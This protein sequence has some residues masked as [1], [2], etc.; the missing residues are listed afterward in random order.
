[1]MRLLMAL[2]GAVAALLVACGGSSGG[3]GNEPIALLQTEVDD[4]FERPREVPDFRFPRDHG[5]HPGFQSEW[6][7]VT[8]NLTGEGRSF[9]YQL[10]IFRFGLAPEGPVA[11]GSWA[12]RQL[13]LA[14]LAVT[15]LGGDQFLTAERISRGALDLAGAR[16]DRL[17]VHVEDFVIEATD[18]G[19][20]SVQL[21]ALDRGF[22][23]DLQLSAV[24]PIVRQGNQGLSAKGPTPGNASYYYSVP[25]WE[26]T[27]SVRVGDRDHDVTGLSWFDREWSTSALE[28][29]QSGWDW[30]AL[31]LDDGTDLMYYGLREESGGFGPYSAGVLVA[32]DGAVRKL[33]ATDLAAHPLDWWESPVTGRTY[34][35]AWRLEG[36]DLALEV[37]A[38]YA[39][40]EHRGRFHYWEGAVDVTG[41]RDGRPVAGSG[42]LEMTG[43]Q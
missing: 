42:Y 32:A 26:T 38:K 12:T 24:K 8:G 16:D 17:A 13:W 15:D 25:R 37:R 30:F 1:M 19:L 9:G 41:T 31:H 2:T 27:G 14:Q 36:T 5:A 43:Y 18:S 22:G 29:N 35:I 11:A 3:D 40:Q 4:G 39:A 21:R 7:Y 20:E 34:P 23:I 33:S 28:G 6:W 10:T